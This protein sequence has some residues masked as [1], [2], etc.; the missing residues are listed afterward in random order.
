MPA[1]VRREGSTGICVERGVEAFLQTGRANRLN[2]CFTERHKRFFVRF[3]V[4]RTRQ[5]RR[6]S[7][8]CRFLTT[9]EIS[10]VGT[11]CLSSNSNTIVIACFH[12]AAPTRSG[13][14]S[15][16]KVQRT[17]GNNHCE[18][19]VCV[20]DAKARVSRRVSY[21][22]THSCVATLGGHTRVCG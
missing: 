9:H 22:A 11:L 21:S 17:K 13:K 4:S 3:F 15:R 20:Q 2:I 14:I 18:S 7:L 5:P 6:R 8:G 19:A 10:R 1:S 16:V 12:L